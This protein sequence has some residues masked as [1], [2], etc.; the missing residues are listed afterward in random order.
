S[1]ES[2]GRH[3]TAVRAESGLPRRR[4]G[5]VDDQHLV[6]DDEAD[7]DD[8][9]QQHDQERQH[10]GKLDRRLASLGP[11]GHLAR[12]RT[13]SRTASSRWP[14]LSVWVAQPVTSKATAAAPSS[15]RAYSVDAWPVWSPLARRSRQP[16]LDTDELTRFI[17]APHR[18]RKGFRGEVSGG[19]RPGGGPRSAA[20]TRAACRGRGGRA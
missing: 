15:T 19:R 17:K 1:G 10:E 20:R 18:E 14:I 9:E 2:G 8:H 6:P 12:R 5:G 13:W 11:A 16:M 7:L 4:A 3:L